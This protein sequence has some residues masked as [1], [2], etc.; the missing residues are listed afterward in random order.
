MG[1][2][3]KILLVE[4]DPEI[5]NFIKLY[6]TKDGYEVIEVERGDLALEVF[7][8]ENPDLV[9]LDILLPGL[10]GIEVCREIRKTSIVPIIILSNKIDETDKIIGLTVGA[11]DYITKPFSP[12]ELSARIRTHL[13][14]KMYYDKQQHEKKSVLTFDHL[15]IDL[16]RHLVVSYGKE[17]DLSAKE[18]NLLICMA[19]HP[20]R[21]FSVEELYERVWGEFSFG[22]TRTVNV[23]ISSLR[24]KI[25]RDPAKPEFILTVRGAGYKFMNV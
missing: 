20:G 25:E 1:L 16:A 22:D 12:R 3:K 15:T 9:M 8:R 4:D 7:A 23:H 14:R 5:R 6:L 11:D 13:R 17:V 21:I 24:K 18:F 19:K 2:D 10:D